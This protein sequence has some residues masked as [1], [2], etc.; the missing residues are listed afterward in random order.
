MCKIKRRDKRSS[1]VVISL[2]C[3]SCI[4]VLLS[5]GMHSKSPGSNLSTFYG[6]LDDTVFRLHFCTEITFVHIL[7]LPC[8]VSHEVRALV[9][10]EVECTFL[11]LQSERQ[12]QPATE[13]TLAQLQIIRS[14]ANFWSLAL[15]LQSALIRSERLPLRWDLTFERR[16]GSWS[17]I[18]FCLCATCAHCRDSTFCIILRTTT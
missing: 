16:Y 10:F 8:G 12:L 17:G 5:L 1:N 7:R 13:C 9:S 3:G 18:L 6:A 2:S 15:C 11:G 14:H 4:P